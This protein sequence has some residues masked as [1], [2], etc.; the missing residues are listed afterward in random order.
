MPSCNYPGCGQTRSTQKLLEKHIKKKH[1][2][3]Y[4]LMEHA[5]DG[6]GHAICIDCGLQFTKMHG[7]QKRCSECHRTLQEIKLTLGDAERRRREKKRVY[8]RKYMR[9]RYWRLK[10]ESSN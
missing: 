1:I 7:A 10:R 6:H 8:M 9:D 5:P 3:E 2:V 4:S